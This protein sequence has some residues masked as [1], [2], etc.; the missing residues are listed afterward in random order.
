M[1]ETE[2]A[3]E[4]REQKGKLKELSAYLRENPPYS[5]A[6]ERFDTVMSGLT[7]KLTKADVNTHGGFHLIISSNYIN[8]LGNYKPFILA[9]MLDEVQR[10]F[11]RAAECEEQL[12][13]EPEVRTAVSTIQDNDIP[14]EIGTQRYSPDNDDD[15][16][17]SE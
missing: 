1:N 10:N 12:C 9:N 13:K 8:I 6:K 2:T 14:L 15:Y 3:A 5:E 17:L 11:E 7:E 4:L 16:S